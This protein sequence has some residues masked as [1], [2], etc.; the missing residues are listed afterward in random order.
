MFFKRK[1][2]DKL[3]TA[4][5]VYDIEAQQDQQA[6]EVKVDVGVSDELIPEYLMDELSKER[7][8]LINE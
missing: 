6:S 4:A 1:Y 3:A 2:S 8:S 7:E 5:G